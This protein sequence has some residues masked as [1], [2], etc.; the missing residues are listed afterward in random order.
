MW[1][2]FDANASSVE[3]SFVVNGLQA[4][5]DIEI[6]DNGDGIALEEI[7]SRFMEDREYF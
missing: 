7:N 6:K 3:I 4:V 2:G 5:T 1:N